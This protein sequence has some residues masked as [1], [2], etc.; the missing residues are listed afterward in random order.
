[1]L[2]SLFVSHGAPTLA[3]DSYPAREFLKGLGALGAAGEGA[4]AKRLHKST[5]YGS[6]RMDA[7]AFAPGRS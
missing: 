6:L 7:Y 2:P 3:L 4:E 5:I 1:M